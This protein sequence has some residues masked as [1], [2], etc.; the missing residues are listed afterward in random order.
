MDAP[1]DDDMRALALDPANVLPRQLAARADQEPDRP[2]LA[3]ADT[4]RAVTYGEFWDECRRWARLLR[5]RGVEA[6]DRIGTM[7]PSSIDAHAAWIGAS[8][9][10]A[11]EVPINPELRGSFLDHVLAD[12]AVGVCLARPQHAATLASAER[13][14]AAELEVVE[15]PVHDSPT[16]TLEPL[17]RPALPT[18]EDVSCVIY[19]SGTTGP[20]KGVVISWAQMATI[21]GRI[22]RRLLSAADAAYSPWP[23]FHVTGRSPMISM[24]DVGGRVVLR[25][26]FSLEAFW[27][28]I[29]AHGC[30]TTTVAA[31]TS[32]LL[33]RPE[34]P[35]DA[36]N[37]LRITLLG[38]VGAEGVRF[39]E[40]F[41]TTGMCF[42]GSTE[43]GFPIGNTDVDAETAD[44]VGWPRPGYETRL[45]DPAGR[46]VRDGE[47]GELWIRPPDRR[48]ILVGYLNQPERTAQAVVDGWYRTG[49]ALRRRPDGAYQFVDRLGDTIRRFGENISSTAVEDEVIAE[50]DVAECVVFGMPSAVAGQEVAV[51]AVPAAG[52]ELDAAELAARLIDRLPR[53][54]R[55]AYVGVVEDLPKTPNGK[56]R[57]VG[58]AD[59]L[60]GPAVWRAG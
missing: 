16:R 19:T 58:L 6:G 53:Y 49:D 26:R 38:R 13:G 41:D 37:P 45:V 7:L 4:G 12:A 1:R 59:M 56:V 8:L 14:R 39:L 57:K 10:G 17:T 55:P 22:P 44:V 36:D 34:R 15:V 24:A 47:V 51:L 21:I 28:D 40:R 9:L 42:Y 60:E 32:L 43:V 29:R 5:Q 31:V 46:D 20:A 2:F 23:M 25:D 30:T 33:A 48:L 52:S 35:D 11:L 18:P 27:P 50:P 3:E 54:M